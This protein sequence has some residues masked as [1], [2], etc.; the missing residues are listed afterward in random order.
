MRNSLHAGLLLTLF[1]VLPSLLFATIADSAF[2]EQKR[3]YWYL[4]SGAAISTHSPGEEAILDSCYYYTLKVPTRRNFGYYLFERAIY[5]K[6][7]GNPQMKLSYALAAVNLGPDFF[8]PLHLW[9]L[10]DMIGGAYYQLEKPS[11]TLTYARK[12]LHLAQQYNLKNQIWLSYYLLANTYVFFELH[13]ISKNYLDKVR[14]LGFNSNFSRGEFYL[15]LGEHYT[16]SG[17]YE[18]SSIALDSALIYLKRCP[19]NQVTWTEI[20][21]NYNKYGDMYKAQRKYARAKAAYHKG[22]LFADKSGQSYDYFLNYLDL[23]DIALSE[24]RLSAARRFLNK[25]KDLRFSTLQLG[26]N[27]RYHHFL[28]DYFYQ[29][30][31][32]DNA[33]INYRLSQ[34]FLKQRLDGTGS[35]RLRVLF[36]SRRNAIYKRQALCYY[37]KLRAGQKVSYDSLFKYLQWSNAREYAANLFYRRKQPTPAFVRGQKRLEALQKRILFNRNITNGFEHWRELQDRRI[38]FLAKTVELPDTVRQASRIPLLTLK[39][40]QTKLEE[41]NSGMLFYLMEQKEALAVYVQADNLLIR[42]LNGS[43]A[44]YRQL[45][46]DLLHPLQNHTG[47]DSVRFRADLAYRLYQ[48]L[49]EPIEQSMALK[50]N[51]VIMPSEAL[52]GLSFGLLLRQRPIQKSYL[53]TDK[54]DYWPDLL[55]QKYNFSISPYLSFLGNKPKTHWGKPGLAVF[56]QPQNREPEQASP[57]A[58]RI[59][60]NLSPL[61]YAAYETESLQKSYPGLSL[62]RGKDANRQTFMDKAGHFDILHFATHAFADTLENAFSGLLLS[63]TPDSADDGLLMGYEIARSNL[64]C[65]LVTLSA[66]ETGR[67]KVVQGE[68]IVGLPRIFIQA[69]ARSVLVTGWDIDDR[70]SAYLAP[71]FLSKL[72]SK[73]VNKAQAL[74]EAKRAV[75]TDP[76]INK[77]RYDYRHPVFWA[78]FNLY[79]DPAPIRYISLF[80]PLAL[81]TLVIL[82]VLLWRWWRRRRLKV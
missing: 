36:S 11:Q 66:C 67:G 33:L 68:G 16:D 24:N 44:A 35:T 15:I 62:F 77:G 60:W 56:S 23:A 49:F 70:Y 2:Y 82:N 73:T 61:V 65:E 51:L 1:L 14:R 31:D 79:G 25:I 78:A 12:A 5:A 39:R 19:P 34:N 6:I 81:L 28:A 27:M 40:L 4:Q 64:K 8:K 53:P 21:Y 52:A 55:L 72:L 7:L 71:V 13:A 50:K 41:T 57:L 75:A 38:G 46:H 30:A 45:T 17:Q 22:L 32:Y 3:H 20:S 74:A 29:K 9:R 18:K 26:S 59:G 58:D 42:K 69:G 10:Y 63:A 37:H 48:R 76:Q 54:A 47:L 80:W 43:E